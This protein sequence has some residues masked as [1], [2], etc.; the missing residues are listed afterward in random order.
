MERITIGQ[1]EKLTSPNPFA[2]FTVRTPIGETNVMAVSWWTFVSNN[3]PIV[4]VSL[5]NSGFSGKCIEYSKAFGLN[6]VGENLKTEAFLA[7]TCSGQNG[8]KANKLRIPLRK[9]DLA[10]QDMIPGSRI[11]LCCSLIDQIKAGDHTVYLGAVD[12]SWGDS[13]V[14]A[15]FAFDGYKC[16]DLVLNQSVK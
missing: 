3:P 13:S 2:L 9:F 7:G 1:A 8:G 12:S 4:A 10:H 16:L 6:I 15:I 5:S 14:D 11:W